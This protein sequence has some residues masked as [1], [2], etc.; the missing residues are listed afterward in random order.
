MHPQIQAVF[1]EFVS[2]QARLGALAGACAEASWARRA[3]PARWSVGE[4]V[5]HLNLTAQA[6]L[7]LIRQ[8]L[9]EA[10]RI[11]GRAS[12]RYRRDLTGWML[13]RSAGPPVRFRTSTSATFIPTSTES[14]EWTVATF[15]Q[16][17]SDQ[18]ACVREADGLP[19][20]RVR[21]VSPFNARLRYNLYACLTILPR[22]Q[23]RHLWQAEQVLE[24]LR[25]G[26]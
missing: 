10:H 2:A 25:G 20:E 14:R 19:L 6:Y 9:D 13:W 7:P 16:L 12:A 15:E 26:R 23:H 22:H 3:D 8:G 5:A 4:C 24:Q 17:Q 1:D 18:L 21:V 11:G